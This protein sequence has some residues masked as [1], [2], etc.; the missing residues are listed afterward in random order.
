MRHVLDTAG[1]I[2]NGIAYVMFGLITLVVLLF[3]IR[4][5]YAEYWITTHCTVVA[6]TRVCQ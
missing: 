2:G 3:I 1:A 4:W 6:G 5:A